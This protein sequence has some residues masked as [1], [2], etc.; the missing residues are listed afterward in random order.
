MV[1]NILT[2]RSRFGFSIHSGDPPSLLWFHSHIFHFLKKPLLSPK[3]L[4][5]AHPNNG[6]NSLTRG[7]LIAP[8]VLTHAPHNPTGSRAPVFFSTPGLSGTSQLSSGMEITE[9]EARFLS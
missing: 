7:K 6:R 4:C 8:K 9:I 2:V 3:S 5:K 1:T